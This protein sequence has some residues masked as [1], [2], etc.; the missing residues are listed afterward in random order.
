MPWGGI[1]E[2]NYQDPTDG[3]TAG[4]MILDEVNTTNLVIP[5]LEWQRE[6]WAFYHTLGELH[7]A[8]GDWLANCMSR[9]RLIAAV[10]RPGE[11]EPSPLLNGPAVDI[12]GE[13][14][15]G[16]GGQAALMKRF[17][18]Q[19]SIPGD[20]YLVGEGNGTLRTWKV[21]SSSEIRIKSRGSKA[22]RGTTPRV[23]TI[24]YEINTQRNDWRDLDP[25]SIVV[26]VWNPDEEYSWAATSAAQSALPIMREIDFYNRY[27]IAVLLSRLA[28]NG[29]LLIPQEV[30]FPAKPQYKDAPDP[31]VAELL[32]IAS[33]SIKNPGSASAALPMPVKVPAQYIE[34]FKH[35]TF[36]TTMGKEVM[37]NR[38]KALQRLATAINVPGEVLTGMANMNHWGQWQL[39]ESAV[40][41]HISPPVEVICAALTDGLLRPMLEAAGEPLV[42]SDGGQIIVWYD[43]SVLVQQPDRSNQAQALYDR[44]EINGVALRRESGFEDDDRPSTEQLKEQALLKIVMAGG[45]DALTALAKLTGDESLVP[46]APAAPPVGGVGEP[47]P[48]E[49]TESSP[50]VQ[51]PAGGQSP[52]DQRK[53]P[54][55]TRPGTEA[56]PPNA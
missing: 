56:Q 17:A 8:I 33:R 16:I 10:K 50:A 7:F 18:V 47:G 23:S 13:I 27:I 48:A 20:S 21:Y 29:L 52:S 51:P 45:A 15:G 54:P 37:E 43:A 14:G 34:Q 12:V 11:D 55:A 22:F 35:L 24:V 46:P 5:P 36:D 4:A 42:N 40:K 53:A 39:E 9:V 1:L 26:R 44:G 31:F 30:T 25:E 32:D 6:A 19:L 3:L 41:I 38:T 49:D 2:K 28:N